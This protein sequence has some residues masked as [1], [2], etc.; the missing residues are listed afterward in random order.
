MLLHRQATE[1]GRT[2][3]R[4]LD[5][6]HTFSFNRYYDPAWMGFRT[7]RVINDDRIAPA[8]GFPTHPHQDMEIVTWVL[9]GV[10]RHRDSTGAEGEIRPGEA[11]R[12]SAGTGI[13]HSEFNGSAEEPLR[14][15][16]IWIEPARAGLAPGYE[17]KYFAPEERQN[18]LRLIASPEGR[19]GSVVIVQDA[20]IYAAL[21]DA[22]ATVNHRLE[23]GRAAWI[24]IAR[25]AATA[26]GVRL[27]EGDGA[28]ITDEALVQIS[29]VE[30]A[31]LLLFDLQ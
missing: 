14:L 22:G 6:R 5:G 31:E 25:G 15:L 3:L 4:W 26:N 16:Q 17:Q 18:R 20:A 19:D 29:G 9:D 7:L 1:R 8:G 27:V 21:L 13:E 28:A 2:Q 30:A 11:Q 10:V 23:P 24:Q 12:M